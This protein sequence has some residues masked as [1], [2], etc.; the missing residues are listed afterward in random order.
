MIGLRTSS[1]KSATSAAAEPLSRPRVCCSLSWRKD[2]NTRGNRAELVSFFNATK[3]VG[4][5][6]AEF[7][8]TSFGWNT[9]MLVNCER[10]MTENTW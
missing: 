8:A 6:T 9:E 7:A 3:L 10:D 4:R 5:V 1:K 2:R